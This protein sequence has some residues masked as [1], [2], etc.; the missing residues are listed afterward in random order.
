[1]SDDWLIFA[2]VIVLSI[3]AGPCFLYYVAYHSRVKGSKKTSELPSFNIPPEIPALIARFD[4]SIKI[5]VADEV[6]AIPQAANFQQHPA[7]IILSKYV[8]GQASGDVVKFKTKH[9]L[10]LVAHE[11]GHIVLASKSTWL[12]TICTSGA[13]GALLFLFLTPIKLGW[14]GVL[15]SLIAFIIFTRALN[16]VSRCDEYRADAFAVTDALIPVDDLAEALTAIKLHDAKQIN[17]SAVQT[18]FTKV[19]KWIFGNS[20]PPV[21]QRI[22][23]IRILVQKR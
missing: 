15:C 9:L 10:A 19:C 8:L 21:E 2:S 20:H 12:L 14:I 5:R 6:T 16:K 1:M 7:Y 18:K 11:L 23:A 17:S 3:L 13:I 22:H 4:R